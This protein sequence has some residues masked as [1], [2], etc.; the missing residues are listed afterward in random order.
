[1]QIYPAIDLYQ[2][3]VVRLT[4]GEFSR[5]TIYSDDPVSTARGWESQGA[6]WIHVVDL[7]GAKTGHLQ[8]LKS[9]RSI[10]KSVSCRIQFGGGLRNV[11]SIQQVFEVG[12]DRAVIG[13]K[14]LDEIFLKHVLD[15]FGNKIAVSLDIKSGV[16]QT[17]GWLQT[18]RLGFKAWLKILNHYPLRTLIYTDIKKDGMLAGPNLTELNQVLDRSKASVILSGGISRLKDIEMCTTIHRDNFE[19][20]IVGTA[21]YNEVFSLAE[22]LKLVT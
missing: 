1:M 17:E 20:V 12:I 21:L 10:R 13:T 7:E 11:E 4:Q 5:K 2:G 16:I 3:K 14:A 15:R 9:L 19:G 18:S 8:N 22:A 6:R